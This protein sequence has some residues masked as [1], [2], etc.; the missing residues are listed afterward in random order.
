ML[1]TMGEGRRKS[2]VFCL[3]R[4]LLSYRDA[5]INNKRA[6]RGATWHRSL[7]KGGLARLL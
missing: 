2:C 6:R 5:P 1:A 4:S 7:E 3:A